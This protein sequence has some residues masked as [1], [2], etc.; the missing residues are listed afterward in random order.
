MA[1][2]GVMGVVGLLVKSL[3]QPHFASSKSAALV[4]IMLITLVAG[5]AFAGAASRFRIPEWEW[6]RS[7]LLRR[8]KRS[9]VVS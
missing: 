5:A 4:Q 3:S 7:K 2:C 9:A 8:G 6:L 1:A